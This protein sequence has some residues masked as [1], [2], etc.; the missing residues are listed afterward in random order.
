[1]IVS[2]IFPEKDYKEFGMVLSM[3]PPK[4]SS[5]VAT[6]RREVFIK[7]TFTI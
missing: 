4:M 2:Q 3:A 7:K 1:M 5:D 6:H